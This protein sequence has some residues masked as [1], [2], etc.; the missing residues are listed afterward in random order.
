MKAALLVEIGCEEIPARMIAGAAADFGARIAAL[1]GQ[2]GLGGSPAAIW[3]GSRRIAVRIEDVP[4]RQADRDERVLGPPAAAAFDAEGKPTP[5]G[6]GFARKQGVDPAALTKVSTEKGEYAG[7]VRR[8]PGKTLAELLQ[9]GLSQAL[10][11]MSFPKTM[12]WGAG[13]HRWVRPVHW[14]V[15]LHGDA[16]LDV[17]AFGVRSGRAS[18]GHRFLAPG[19]VPLASTGDYERALQRAFVVVDP[20]A[21][22]ARLSERLAIEAKALG[23]ALVE[24]GELLDEIVELVE[25]PGVVAGRFDPAFLDLPEEVL[26]TT[27]RHHQKA[28]SVRAGARLAP[29]FLSVANTDRDPSGHIRRGNE[30]VVSGRLED[31][32]FFW[33]ED[34]KRTLASRFEDLRK[35]V[36]HVKVGSYADKA[37]A[38]GRLADRLGAVAGLDA[39]SRR[40]AYDAGRLAKADLV[41]GLVGEFPELQGIVGGL[42]LRAEGAERE[43]AEAVYDH[44]RPAGADDALPG[45]E[46]GCVVAAADRIHTIGALIGIGEAPTGSRDP[47]G[48]RRAANGVFRIALERRWRVG[49]EELATLAASPGDAALTSFFVERLHN[50][51]RDRGFTA[52]EIAATL[53]PK[54]GAADA[55]RWPLHEILARLEVVRT[56]RGRPDFT[57]LV[58]LTKRVDNILDKRQEIFDAAGPSWRPGPYAEAEAA[59]LA[60]DALET[61]VSP[62]VT[63]ASEAGRFEAVVDL[64]ARYVEPV[65]AFFDSVLVLDPEHLDATRARCEI[66]ARV[67]S[68]VTRDFDIRELAGQADRRA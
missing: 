37:E 22:R 7:F 29:V 27:L 26:V 51:L 53:R 4:G 65:A 16:V 46:I 47:F 1:L 40:R 61:A 5:A 58:E 3:G 42:L 38:L 45:S 8:V 39:E 41:T 56:L 13:T 57:R 28:F 14:I 62:E 2:A 63:R 67:R 25:W 18:D 31:A 60:L 55:L 12:R 48:L 19:P 52:N 64:L 49:I 6:A 24:D 9:A 54:V 10:S 43:T 66:L 20:A 59:A 23:G 32:R 33:S 36:F 34:R 44:Y 35:V 50:F 21:R 11:G 15:A 68:T 30:W 17:E